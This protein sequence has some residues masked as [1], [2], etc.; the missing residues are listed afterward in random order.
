MLTES[1]ILHPLLLA[2]Q[3]LPPLVQIG[4]LD[5][6]FT[7]AS[8]LLLSVLRS[9][10]Y[11]ILASFGWPVRS[12]M[13][14]DAAASITSIVHSI[15][16]CTWLTAWFVKLGYKHYV[17]SCKLSDHKD[18]NVRDVAIACLEFCT[19]YML[20]DSFWFLVAT[21]QLGLMPPT[22]FEMLV[23]AHHA[24]TSFYMISCRVIEAG[25]ISAM[26]LMLTGEVSNPLMNGMFT[27]R[28]AVQLK[29]CSSDN[30][31][32]L[33]SLMEHSFAVVYLIFRIAIGPACAIHLAWDVLFTQRGRQNIPLPLSL[34]WVS[35][36]IIVIAGSGPFILEAVEML[37]DGWEL[38]FPPNFDY[39][40]R[41]QIQN[42]GE[43]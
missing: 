6:T 17:P 25:H 38:K 7:L 19:G 30:M 5:F 32:L 26:I 35:M 3:K 18:K 12:K 42:G 20:F 43:L 2:Y 21:Y 27:T 29:C 37:Q 39:G 24:L 36:V 40:E 41:F 9:I 15:A 1:W 34:I 11:Q 22:E 31:M 8:F 23:L 4:S 33:H 10:I 16:L 14:T 13:T 28:F